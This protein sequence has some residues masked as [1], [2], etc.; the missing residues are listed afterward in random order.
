MQAVAG[1]RLLLKVAADVPVAVGG[2]PAGDR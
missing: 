2:A 1:L